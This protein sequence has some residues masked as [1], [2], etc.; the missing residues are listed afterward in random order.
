M[1]TRGVA[2][3]F[4]T[5]GLYYRGVRAEASQVTMLRQ[6]LDRW[7]SGL[8]LAEFGGQ[9]VLL[10]S[11][12]ALANAVEHA[13]ADGDG[14]VDLEAKYSPQDRC[15]EIVVTD[16]GHWRESVTPTAGSS[17]GHGL[18]LIRNLAADTDLA[19]NPD[20]TVVAMRWHLPHEASAFS[21]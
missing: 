11:Y 15:V 16:H 17:R 4:L 10:A 12:E 8:R 19:V 2:P 18:A 1:Q 5:T 20:G 7:L 14:T 3:A 21:G 9:D 6:A 13:Y